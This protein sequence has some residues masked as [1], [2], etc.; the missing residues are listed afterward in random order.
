MEERKLSH[1]TKYEDNDLQYIAMPQ[2]EIDP[3]YIGKQ[4][5]TL[6]LRHD[7]TPREAADYLRDL[8]TAE[9]VAD[10]LVALLDRTAFTDEQ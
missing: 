3:K 5:P 9:W 1:L 2:N 7:T 10:L 6:T 8:Y 4:P